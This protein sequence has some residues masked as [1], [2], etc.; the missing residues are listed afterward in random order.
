MYS[1]SQFKEMKMKGEEFIF[2]YFICR[3][4]S[5]T[6]NR[7]SKEQEEKEEET[8]AR[9]NVRVHLFSLQHFTGIIPEIIPI[10]KM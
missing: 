7:Y 8:S 9:G 4:Q 1:T 2:S 3:W 10:S 5:R 6:S